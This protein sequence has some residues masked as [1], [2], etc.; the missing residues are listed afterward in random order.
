MDDNKTKQ[1][2]RNGTATAGPGLSSFI[3]KYYRAARRN[4]MNPMGW[5]RRWA[6]R[7]IAGRSVAGSGASR[8][9]W[10]VV[11]GCVLF[12]G[13]LGGLW[14]APTDPGQARSFVESWLNANRMPLGERM[15]LTVADV[16]P[17]KDD[18]GQTIFY[19]V[20]LVPEGYVV[21]AAEDRIQPVI[22]FSPS[23]SFEEAARGPLGTLITQDMTSRM[24]AVANP[25]RDADF[26]KTLLRNQA[27]WQVFLKASD[28]ASGPETLADAALAAVSDVRVAPLTHSTWDQGSVATGFCY[29]YFT[30]NNYVCGCVATAMA[31]LM[32]YHQYPTEGVGTAT[33]DIT[34][35]GAPTTASLRGGDGNGGPY[36]WEDMPLT[37]TT[38]SDTERR[39]IGALCFD[40][41]VAAHMQY[42]AAGSGA[43]P[44]DATEALRSVFSYSNAVLGGSDAGIQIAGSVLQSMINPNL[45]ARY[46]VMLSIYGP[47]VGHEI[48]ADG[49]GFDGNVMY[50]HLNMGWGGAWDM[51]YDLPNITSGYTFDTV[52]GCT[53][54]V[55]PHMTGEIIS[56]RV[57]DGNGAPLPGTEVTATAAGGLV[58]TTTAD[59]NGI[60]AFA[61]VPSDTAFRLSAARA[62]F[63]FSSLNVTTGTSR[64][65]EFATGNVWG[66]DLQ[67][68]AY[69]PLI[70][71]V[72]QDVTAKRDATLCSDPNAGGLLAYVDP[73]NWTVKYAYSNPED[74]GRQWQ[75]PV[76][77]TNGAYRYIDPPQVFGRAGETIHIVFGATDASGV[78]H[79]Y[80]TYSEDGGATWS[81]DMV[82]SDT[83]QAASEPFLVVDPDDAAPDNDVLHVFWTA[84]T[85]GSTDNLYD[86]TQGDVLVADSG[87]AA[88]DGTTTG[89]IMEGNGRIVVWH[90]ADGNRRYSAGDEV[91]TEDAAA[92]DMT[93]TA[94]V[95]T[96]VS[97]PTPADG[98]SA[99]GVLYG[100]FLDDTNGNHDYDDGEVLWI[101]AR[102]VR[103][104]RIIKTTGWGVG[105][106]RDLEANG[107]PLVLGYNPKAAVDSAG[108]VHAVWYSAAGGRVMYNRSNDAGGSWLA[109]PQQ[110]AALSTD[111]YVS[112]AVALS[113]GRE[114]TVTDEGRKVTPPETL[115]VIW[116]DDTD[117]AAQLQEVVSQTP[118]AADLSLSAPRAL[119]L[120]PDTDLITGDGSA[121]AAG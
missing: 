12:M 41:G 2:T 93:F 113:G 106:H 87:A 70:P 69:L 42:S 37:P 4:R 43:W 88:V 49:Y 79:I 105:Q 119:G 18:N 71:L 5:M 80:Y 10:A 38:A 64:D 28:P 44:S 13:G 103:Y 107:A 75:N 51:W 94:G 19:V 74:H 121:R 100:A 112:P 109:T 108:N 98:T 114:I 110:V 82:I 83:D 29:N 39:A 55:F 53:Y 102:D 9:G 33:Y 16:Q 48:V 1:R 14:A 66:A 23:G 25:P 115:H 17:G 111:D 95:D 8:T 52:S 15:P 54:N 57:L 22:A 35:D 7:S 101:N 81:A 3:L 120:T 60:Y 73:S 21:V 62:G 85:A 46:P 99:S 32:R 58:L 91:W 20:S 86:T 61:G 92:A 72:S 47:G 11:L 67:S 63:F 90:D 50:H 24:A 34:V 84:A 30:P 26:D 45:D 78:S 68:V 76:T 97:T 116:G 36:A 118:A 6:S 96:E 117:P 65:N 59:E 104:A 27:R 40:A 77:A 56:G 31:Q 89:E